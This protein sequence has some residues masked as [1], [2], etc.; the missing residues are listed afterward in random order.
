M[1]LCASLAELKNVLCL[2][3]LCA[4]LRDAGL[5]VAST[6]HYQNLPYFTSMEGVVVVC[7]DGLLLPARG[8]LLN[9]NLLW[10]NDENKKAINCM[11]RTKEDGQLLVNMFK[12]SSNSKNTSYHEANL[13][14]C[15]KAA[16]IHEH[17]AN[18]R[19]NCMS[20][21]CG[22]K[23]V[24]EKLHIKL[25]RLFI[26]LN[27]EHC[28]T[29]RDLG[30]EFRSHQSKSKCPRHHHVWQNRE[31][32]GGH[33]N[34]Q[35]ARQNVVSCNQRHKFREPKVKVHKDQSGSDHKSREASGT[36][37]CNWHFSVP[38]NQVREGHG[39]Q[40]GTEKY[41]PGAFVSK[42]VHG[43]ASL[44]ANPGRHGLHRL[45]LRFSYKVVHKRRRGVGRPD[46]HGQRGSKRSGRHVEVNRVD[47]QQ[48]SL[49]TKLLHQ[50]QPR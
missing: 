23:H 19:H 1:H 10:H 24:K 13:S 27:S 34:G 17:S 35:Q 48:A 7:L 11:R 8:G 3:I 42:K 29:L 32:I 39:Q 45:D 22:Q 14:R 44:H 12:S 20:T 37:L 30:A 5:L 40:T 36:C 16:S 26:H 31:A 47:T 28:E 18:Q 49:P 9:I 6:H 38:S 50:D 21:E 41:T 43:R 2:F 46:D 15:T 25:H 33:Q 4:K